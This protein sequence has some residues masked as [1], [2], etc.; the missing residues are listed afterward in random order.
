MSDQLP[1]RTV[2]AIIADIEEAELSINGETEHYAVFDYWAERYADDVK[3]VT[4]LLLSELHHAALLE[5]SL[6]ALRTAAR[7]VIHLA[8]TTPDSVQYMG[9]PVDFGTAIRDLRRAVEGGDV[10]RKESDRL[11]AAV[12]AELHEMVDEMAN[13]G[14]GALYILRSMESRC[15]E[16]HRDIERVIHNERAAES[17]GRSLQQKYADWYRRET[18]MSRD[19]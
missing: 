12:Q 7:A 8:E 13:P 11:I 19:D 18:G 2:D 9:L 5:L 1:P 6:D 10:M 14:M 17:Q 16:R 15:R 3:I 4:D